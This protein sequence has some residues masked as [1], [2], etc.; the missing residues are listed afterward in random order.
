[1]IFIKSKDEIQIMREAGAIVAELMLRLEEMIRQ[2]VTTGDLDRMAEK[3]IRSR[4]AAPTFI[5]YQGYPKTLCTSI[6]EEVVHG[7]PGPKMLREGDVIGVDCGVTWK[8]FVADHAKTFCVGQ[9]PDEKRKLIKV[10]GEALYAGIAAFQ[11]GHRVGDISS[12]VQE[13]AENHGY[14]IVKD[15]VGHGVGRRMHEEPQVPNFGEKKTGP[16]L[17][18]GMVLAIEP[19]FNLGTGEVKILGDAWTVVT[20]DDRCSAHFEHTIAL[21]E[22]G[23]E[24]LTR[25]QQI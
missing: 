22:A 8:G 7:I 14:G 21:T 16:R 4:G 12:A 15:F 17:K 25:I 20:K 2:G 18:S 10:T 1:M 11:A 5:G 24:I 3:F 23:T 19:M 13:V 9:V 6:N